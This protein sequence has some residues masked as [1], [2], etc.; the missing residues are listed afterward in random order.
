VVFWS[1]SLPISSA[2]IESTIWLALALR[3]WALRKLART[4]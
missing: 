3:S 4:R 2:T 1:G